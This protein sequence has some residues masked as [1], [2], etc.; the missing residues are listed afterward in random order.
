MSMFFSLALLMTVAPGDSCAMSSAA[1]SLTPTYVGRELD[2][3][4][5][6]ALRRWANRSKANVEPAAREFLAFYQ[7]VQKDRT[8][9]FVTRKQLAAKLRYR[10]AALFGIWTT[11]MLRPPRLP[12]PVPAACWPNKPAVLTIRPKAAPPAEIVPATAIWPT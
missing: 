11:T 6:A 1:T 3:A 4:V 5:H 12:L 10:L 2:Q 7:N 9:A 8:L